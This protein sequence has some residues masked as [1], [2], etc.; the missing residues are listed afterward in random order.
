MWW[1]AGSRGPRAVAI[2]NRHAIRFSFKGR[3]RLLQ[4]RRSGSYMR[5]LLSGLLLLV[6]CLRRLWCFTQLEGCQSGARLVQ[7][8]IFWK[9]GKPVMFEK[10]TV[11]VRAPNLV[12][13]V[14]E[15]A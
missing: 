9:N 5:L 2:Y 4:G 10:Q 14:E 6:R 1:C 13:L 3:S 7:A 12:A 11:A 8:S 15:S